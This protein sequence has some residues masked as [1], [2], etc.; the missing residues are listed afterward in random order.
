MIAWLAVALPIIADN[1]LG[2]GLDQ[3]GMGEKIREKFRADPVKEAFKHALQH[4]FTRLEQ[5]YPV[6]AQ[7]SLFRASFEDARCGRVLTQLLLRR[8]TPD[9]NELAGLWASVKY[10]KTSQEYT[11]SLNT[12]GPLAH[13]FLTLLDNALANETTLQALYDSKDLDIT[14]TNTTNIDKNVEKILHTLS[15]EKD[16]PQI[17]HD[18][19]HWLLGRNMYLDL[20]GVPQ[21]Q[22]QVQVKLE[23]V[24]IAL[25]AQ[26]DEILSTSE[27]SLL[28][29]ELQELEQHAL[30]SRTEDIDDQRDLIAHRFKKHG[31]KP[32]ISE[33]AR[34]EIRDLSTVVAQHDRVLI[35]G[36]PGCGK[37]TLLRYLALKHAQAT[38]NNLRE[39]SSELGKARFPI[40]LRIADYA[41]YGK[42]KSLSDFLADYCSLNEY[43]YPRTGLAE[44]F[45]AELK[46]GSCLVLLDGLDEIVSTDD[47]LHVVRHIEDFVRH[48]HSMGNRFVITSRIAGYRNARLN[49]DYAHYQVQEMDDTQIRHFL[50][51]WCP[52]VEYVQ[53]PDLS[54]E[55]RMVTAKREINGIMDAVKHTPGVRRLAAN[56]L[57][58][59]TLALIHRTGA[60]L[61]QKRIEL[62]KLAAEVLTRTWRVAQGVRSTALLDEGEITQLLR[63]LAYWMHVHKPTGV[64]TEREIIKVWASVK[65]KDEDDLTVEQEVKAFLHEVEVHTGLFV[66]R[67][68]KRYGFMH[69][70]FEEYYAA[71]YLV[72]RSR[73]RAQLIRKHLH[74]PRWEEPILL[75]LGFVGMDAPED[76]AEL[77]DTAILAQGELAVELGFMPSKYEDLLGR[78]YLFALRCL[79]DQMPVNDKT[80][81]PIVERLTNELLYQNGSAQYQRYRQALDERL[82]YLKGS[83]A[84]SLL[85][86][87][88]LLVLN[89][90]NQEEDI[91]IRVVE[92]LVLLVKKNDAHVTEALL[93]SLAHDTNDIVRRNVASSLGQ[94]ASASPEVVTALLHALA[95]DTDDIV[96]YSVAQSLGQVASASP[97]VVTALL[98]ALAHDTDDIV[99][100]NVASSLGQLTQKLSD[101]IS[102]VLL[103][104]LKNSDDWSTRQN[105]ARLIGR[106]S[107]GNQ[108]NLQALYQGLL[109]ADNDIRTACVRGLVT[110]ARRFPGI[111]EAVEKMLMRAI[112]QKKFDKQDNVGRSAHDYAYEGL[113]LLVVGGEIEDK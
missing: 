56:P 90:N 89:N 91:R 65:A 30:L 51:M 3:S 98:H 6:L 75:A 88:L 100:R 106:L 108:Q 105:V 101:E 113:W 104:A 39:A 60:M 80:M 41:E 12:F 102:I 92:R 107:E 21:T 53:T 64:A 73:T 40:L 61:P 48:H 57:L 47:R 93:H 49:G 62:Y 72:A 9:P 66:E 2:Y 81:R 68:P 83:K 13:D 5:S 50:D 110:L 74:E 58:L 38:Q 37:T 82:K 27:R 54:Q 103:E 70:T 76:A 87:R 4:T 63:E 46:S 16:L 55:A 67:A 45:A 24:Y 44:M 84:A 35:L 31:G 52:A 94:V 42:G 22:R 86:P 28:E 19:L 111:Y 26:R 29:K 99:R 97:E 95:H 14:A 112:K 79:G 18:Y 33:R 10:P 109:D 17:R 43:P 15:D 34:G 77:I 71:R 20:R 96:R 36:D 1:V 25:Q 85:I 69:L 7:E 23:E 32:P 8:D 78:D 59:C 11:K